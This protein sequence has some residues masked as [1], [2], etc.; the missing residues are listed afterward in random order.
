MSMIIYNRLIVSDAINSIAVLN[1]R[2]TEKS[3]VFYAVTPWK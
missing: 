1:L 3:M 2:L